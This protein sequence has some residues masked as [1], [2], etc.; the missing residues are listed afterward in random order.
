[1]NVGS[2]LAALGLP[3]VKAEAKRAAHRRVAVAGHVGGPP[4]N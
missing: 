1:M 4:A 3:V 2:L